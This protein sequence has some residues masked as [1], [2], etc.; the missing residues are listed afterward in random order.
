ML[1]GAWEISMEN[2]KSGLWIITEQYFSV[3][4]YQSEPANFSYTEGGEWKITSDGHMEF[5]W[6][7]HTREKELVGQQRIYSFRLEAIY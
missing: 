3:T 5:N 2:G 6:K 4:Y 7:Y 1:Q